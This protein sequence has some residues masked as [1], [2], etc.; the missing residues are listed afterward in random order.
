MC[1]A[2]VIWEC[3]T[4]SSPN[5]FCQIRPSERGDIERKRGKKREELKASLTFLLHRRGM[6]A[7]MGR[8][9][10]KLKAKG[11]GKWKYMSEKDMLDISAKFAPY[12]YVRFPCRLAGGQRDV[13]RDALPGV[14]SCGT[15]GGSRMSRLKRC[16]TNKK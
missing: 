1:L 3:S 11:G 16:R 7:L 12:R 9:V 15:C 5:P 14:C 2:R 10:A 6:A 4:F 13:D 8:D